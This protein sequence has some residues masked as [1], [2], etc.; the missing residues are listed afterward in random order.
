M[1]PISH[2]DEKSKVMHVINPEAVDLEGYIERV[3]NAIAV[4]HE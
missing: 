1:L 3:T 4:Y 2:V